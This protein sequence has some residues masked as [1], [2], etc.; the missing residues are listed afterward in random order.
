MVSPPRNEK[1]SQ[2]PPSPRRLGSPISTRSRWKP[3]RAAPNGSSVDEAVRTRK[4]RIE[5]AGLIV[6]S[7]IAGVPT[8]EL[9]AGY[10]CAPQSL[11]R[12]R[13]RAEAVLAAAVRCV[14]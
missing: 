8:A 11:R 5:D 7:R 14:A 4:L 2:L 12:R 10:G 3:L 6:M 1:P 9:A 13:Q